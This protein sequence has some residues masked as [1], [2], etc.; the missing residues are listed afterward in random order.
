MR[1]N[2]GVFRIL[3]MCGNLCTRFSC[4]ILLH[5]T[6]FK[7]SS[8]CYSYFGL[9]YR[10]RSIVAGNFINLKEYKDNSI[11]QLLYKDSSSHCSVYTLN[12]NT[13]KIHIDGSTWHEAN[14]N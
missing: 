11:I 13:T 2:V 6:L 9:S 8:L 4:P 14:N 10:K 3:I 12:K 7:L 5:N 1:E